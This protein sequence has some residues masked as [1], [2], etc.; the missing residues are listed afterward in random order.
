VFNQL[1]PL[2]RV[3]YLFMKQILILFVLIVT[4]A[5][6]TSCSGQSNEGALN[7]KSSSALL[8]DKAGNFWFVSEKEGVFRYDGKS[9]INYTEKDGMSS[10]FVYCILEDNEGILWFGTADGISCFD[11]KKFFNI[12][13]TTITNS[14]SYRKTTTNNFGVP[15]PQS[16]FVQGF[17]LD[18]TGT[19]WIGTGNGVYRYNGKTYTQFANNDGIV[20][21][22]GFQINGIETFLQ[23]KNGN[24]WFGG[25]G[26]EGLFRFDGKIVS[27][28][29]LDD[30]MW[31]RPLL[32]DSKGNLWF[33]SPRHNM[34][35]CYEGKE[36]LPFGKNEI[37][38]WVFYMT[39]DREGNLWFSNG[40]KGGVTFYD[41]KTNK[42]LTKNDGLCYETVWCIA[43]DKDGNVWFINRDESLCR[44]DGK[45]FMSLS[46]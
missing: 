35:Y 32:E 34:I 31:V 41:G 23:D 22:T 36:F 40:L 11:G 5:V 2:L 16:N 39:E 18:K 14:N 20:N 42:N 4:V 45:S 6:F 30:K 38:D 3:L 25:R 1:I 28:F 17:L 12:P 15:F 27:H 24:V 7:P 37:K 9:F 29:K 13:I 33:G 21:N 8:Q 26:S 19:L 43:S 46:K 10:N 44:Y